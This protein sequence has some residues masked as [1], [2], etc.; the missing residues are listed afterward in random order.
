MGKR[1]EK[2]WRGGVEQQMVGD[3]VH[4]LPLWEVLYYK[5]AQQ[6]S[7]QA[8]GGK[9][10]REVHLALFAPGA[11]MFTTAGPKQC[12]QSH[13]HKCLEVIASLPSAVLRGDK[14]QTDTFTGDTA[15]TASHFHSM[16]W[17]NVFW[18]PKPLKVY[19]NLLFYLEITIHRVKITCCPNV[20]SYK[21]LPPCF[22]LS[23]PFW[24]AFFGCSLGLWGCWEMKANIN[25]VK[26]QRITD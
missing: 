17:Q 5:A 26:Q 20:A 1:A 24:S 19:I 9:C 11:P 15:T 12:L 14:T 2:G 8:R 4:F 7:L 10:R 23:S 3:Q 16:M 13:L 6:P 21:C 22:L 18:C 25:K